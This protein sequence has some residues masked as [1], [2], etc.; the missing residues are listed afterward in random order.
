[1]TAPTCF[2]CVGKDCRKANGHE[3]LRAALE[4]HANVQLVRCQ[5]VCKGPVAGVQV[6]GHLEWFGRL[7]KGKHRKAM[8]K[9]VRSRARRIPE[10]LAARRDRKR[11]DL[12]RT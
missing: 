4:Q 3:D 2:V 10:E 8:A 6:D 5:K 11:R 7:R 12:L 9:L 1:V